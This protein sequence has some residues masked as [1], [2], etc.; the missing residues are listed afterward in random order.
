[1][2]PDKRLQ[3]GERRFYALLLLVKTIF[4]LL[5]IFSPLEVALV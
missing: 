4:M 1:M 2:Q 3:L 5:D